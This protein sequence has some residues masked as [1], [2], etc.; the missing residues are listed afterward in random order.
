MS[1]LAYCALTGTTSRDAYFPQGKWYCIYDGMMVVSS[2][3]G[4][5]V[6]LNAPIDHIPV[7]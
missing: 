5:T 6:T 1:S 7:R 2:D 3:N 4:A